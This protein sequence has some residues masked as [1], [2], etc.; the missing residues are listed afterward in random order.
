MAITTF[1]GTGV[2]G[3]SGDGGAATSAQLNSLRGVATDAV[4]NVYMCIADYYNNNI[5]MVSSSGIITTIAGTGAHGNSGD[6]GAATSATLYNPT[7]VAVD[8]L[9]NVYIA[10]TYN[11]KIR[12][13]TSAGI[14]TTFAGTGASG[15]SGDTG[16]ATS[17]QLNSPYGV[18]VGLSGSLFI[19]D[20]YN[21]N[22]RMVS[23]NGIIATY[24]GTGVYGYS[25]DGGAATSA[26]FAYPSGVAVNS[27]GTLFIAD[28]NNYVIRMVSTTGIITNFAGTGGVSGSTGDGGALT[29]CLLA[30]PSRVAVDSSNRVYVTD[31]NKVRM[32]SSA[33][34]CPAGSYVSS[35]SSGTC[36]S[37]PIGS[38]SASTSFATSCPLCLAGTYGTSP[39]ATVCTV[40][41]A[42]T[43][44]FVLGATSVSSCSTVR[45]V[46]GF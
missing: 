10:D 5:R 21:Y 18:A 35:T 36:E 43:M 9:F 17:A 40:C 2:Y 37:C 38:Y 14:I 4:G 3:S 25:G 24:A 33:Y 28:S 20:M 6:T 46:F 31:G 41:P 30:S 39:G 11:S 44:N 8:S 45:E 13:I 22:V 12:K 26:T 15:N 19:V 32:I 42:G 27:V 23:S 34:V 16:A 7:G 1:A 29:S